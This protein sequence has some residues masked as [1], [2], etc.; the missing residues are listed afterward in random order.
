MAPKLI[1]VFR[2]GKSRSPHQDKSYIDL[3]YFMPDAPRVHIVITSRSSAVQGITELEGVEVAGMEA[4][5]AI[6]L[7]QRSAKMTKARPDETSD[8][9]KIV[10]ELG[11]LALAITLAGSY[12]SVTPR[13]S[14]DIKTYL[15]EYRKR[16]QEIFRRRPKRYIHRYKERVFTTW[17]SSFE[18]I[19]GI[20]PAAVR[21]L[22]LLAFINYKDIF[23]NLFDRDGA[24]TLAGISAYAGNKSEAL[25]LSDRAW[26]S[27]FSSGQTWTVPDLE[28]AFETLQSYSLVQWRSDQGSYSIHKLVHAW[29][30]DRLEAEQQRQ[31]S[32]LALELVADAT[33]EKGVKPSKNDGHGLEHP[34]RVQK[35]GANVKEVE[36]FLSDSPLATGSSS[37]VPGAATDQPSKSSGKKGKGKKGGPSENKPTQPGSSTSQGRYIS[38]YDF[39][40][41]GTY[42]CAIHFIVRS[43]IYSYW[44]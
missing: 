23:T 8:I 9:S 32:F 10:E 37:A 25:M 16:W 20:N 4:S 38:V 21:L 13:L 1:N 30:Y 34:P 36:F 12:V 26:R 2:S 41:N 31:L 11:Y 29:S 39:F 18:A 40:K 42:F 44:R 43:V 35:H 7:F 24:D 28:S 5:E 33:V 19:K 3:Q 27:F 22:S 6:E 14:S 17:E 15:P